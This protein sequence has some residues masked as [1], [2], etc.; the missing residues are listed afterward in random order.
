[1]KQYSYGERDYAF[2]QAMQSLRSRIG[3]TQAGL[4][5]LLGL[6]PRAV[7]KWEAGGSYPKA[8][9][10][11]QLIALGVQQQVFPPGREAEEIR[12]FWKAAHQK[13]L[14]DEAWLSTLLKEPSSLPTLVPV[15]ET[16]HDDEGSVPTPALTDSAQAWQSLLSLKSVASRAPSARGP[17]VDWGDALDVPSFYGREQ[18]L[19]RL[20]RW[21]G[22]ERCRLVSVLGLGG[23]GKSALVVRAMRE[24]AGHFDVVLFRALR[25]VPSCEALLESCLAVLASEPQAPGPESLERRL[26]RLL[27]ELRSLRVLLVLDNLEGLLEAGDV[28]GHLRPGYEGYGRLLELVAQTGQHSCLLLISREKPA[29]L[30]TLEA[31]GSWCAPC[32]SP[33]WR[34]RQGSSSWPGMR[35]QTPPRSAP[36]WWSAMRAIRWPSTS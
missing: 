18:D 25:D 3:L 4:A 6:S 13:A 30:D 1:M 26:S 10:L 14:L 12:A 23:I 28:L 22:E 29:V 8:E 34:P 32:A 15:E 9:R 11:K 7:A 24:L 2:G 36:A 19:A 31:R 35:S 16:N 21:V 33:G 27:A 5:D 20:T 17:R